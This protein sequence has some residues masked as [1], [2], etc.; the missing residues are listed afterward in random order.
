MFVGIV[1]RIAFPV[2]CIVAAGGCVGMWHTPY[3]ADA[4]W[5]P[6][7]QL[8]PSPDAFAYEP[9][10]Q[11]PQPQRLPEVHANYRKFLIRFADVGIHGM[12]ALDM[13]SHYYRS[14][15]D[16]VRRLVIVLPIWG[17]YPY[18]P[19]RMTQTLLRRSKGE[20]DVLHLLGEEPLFDW[21]Q[22]RDAPSEREFIEMAGQM[23]GRV[24]DAVIGIRQIVDWAQANTGLEVSVVGFSMGAIV[25]AIV[26]GVDDRVSSGA[27]MMGAGNPGEAF[28][29]C[30]GRIGEMR[31]AVKS[32]FGWSQQRYRGFFESLLADGD[33]RNFI[34]RYDP[35]RIVIID[36]MFDGC[37]SR[38]SR[39]ALWQATGRPERITYFSNHKWSFLSLT[40]LALN[41]AGKKIHGFLA[42]DQDQQFEQFTVQIGDRA[43]HHVEPR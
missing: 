30:N 1:V 12:P 36:G 10:A 42:S 6:A 31:D 27:L 16:D 29:T 3:R 40:P 22:L 9:V 25:A 33:P 41:V 2:I 37:M 35:Q 18:P 43:A 24:A 20:F 7:S 38:D 34:G 8:L 21:E 26:L 23:T 17:S 13:T 11:N 5:L 4:A 32:R 28:A 19:R 39:A 14:T 15:S